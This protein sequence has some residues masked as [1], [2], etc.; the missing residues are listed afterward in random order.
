MTGNVNA[1]PALTG[2]DIVSINPTNWFIIYAYANRVAPSQVQVQVS[3]SNNFFCNKISVLAINY[4]NNTLGV[5]LIRGLATIDRYI[6]FGGFPDYASS[7]DI[8]LLNSFFYGNFYIDLLNQT[9]VDYSHSNVGNSFTLNTNNF[10]IMFAYLMITTFT[11][12]NCC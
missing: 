12:D 9:F 2:L 11:A 10:K 8:T 5:G 6:V 1:W 3:S 7:I 4:N